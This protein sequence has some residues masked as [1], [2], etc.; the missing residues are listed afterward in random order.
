[1]YG[2]N[3]SVVISATNPSSTPKDKHNVVIYF[4]TMEAILAGI[5][6][7]RFIRSEVN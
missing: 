3:Q 2:S 4:R 6:D 1:M 7:I 5:V